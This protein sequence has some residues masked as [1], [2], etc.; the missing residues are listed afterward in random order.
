MK[1]GG[2]QW[3][4]GGGGVNDLKTSV[5]LENFCH[6]KAEHRELRGEHLAAG[7]WES[8]FSREA[9]FGG[10]R[11]CGSGQ[12]RWCEG[13]AGIG[14]AYMGSLLPPLSPLS[15]FFTS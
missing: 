1:P 7:G 5:R 12:L 4:G 11:F 2:D 3:L 6:G 10:G 8:G 14:E 13:G 9:I 15:L